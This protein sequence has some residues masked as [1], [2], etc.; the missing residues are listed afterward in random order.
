MSDRREAAARSPGAAN[1]GT[2][3]GPADDRERVI[4]LECRLEQMRSALGAAREEADAARTNLAESCAREADHARRSAVLHAELAEARAEVAALHRRLERS[5]ALK[6]EIEGYLFEAGARA[7]TDELARLRTRVLVEDQRSLVNDRAL[8]RLRWRVEDLAATRETLLTRVAEWQQLIR[9]EGPDAADLSEFLAEL[10]SE[11][12]ELEHRNVTSE[13]RE[14]FLRERLAMA[15]LDPDGDPADDMSAM[16]IGSARAEEWDEVQEPDEQDVP[17]RLELLEEADS[18]ERRDEPPGE[19]PA[20]A[21][22]AGREDAPDR[23]EPSGSEASTAELEV[24]VGAGEPAGPET[25]AR[26]DQPDSTE[27]PVSGEVA[28]SADEPAG[29]GAPAGMDEPVS[30]DAPASTDEPAN[31]EVPIEAV[32]SESADAEEP[33]SEPPTRL[34]ELVATTDRQSPPGTPDRE[35]T[36]E[37]DDAGAD[38]PS[39]DIALPKGTETKLQPG[40]DDEATPSGSD[41]SAAAHEEP[42]PTPARSLTDPLIADLMAA[43]SSARRA[44][45]LLRI[46]RSGDAR[47]HKVIR[48]WTESLEPSVRAAAYEALGRLLERSPELLEPHLRAGLADSDPRVRRRVALATATARGLTPRL[49]LEPLKEDPDPQVRRVVRE[50]L[51]QARS[52]AAPDPRFD[53]RPKPWSA[54]R[55]DHASRAEPTGAPAQN[56]SDSERSAQSASEQARKD[57]HGEPTPDH[58][59][60]GKPPS[61]S[62]R[63]LRTR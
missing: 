22:G 63:S 25:P 47:A 45:L 61:T 51:R 20:D 29:P 14:M 5:E 57:G 21:D 19:E 26:A 11:I 52:G 18:A 31:P 43:E 39:V 36:G 3:P 54:R 8:A 42:V 49:L 12:L 53:G 44:D 46:G 34:D 38:A 16:A 10:R 7:D 27:E 37:P 50:V 59:S 30:T 62:N 1:S 2:P 6:A 58:E 35:P 15:G 41:G 48:P 9:K 40:P 23:A 17:E 4:L 32:D 13:A 33:L 60:N 28:D 55:V 24:P 56:T